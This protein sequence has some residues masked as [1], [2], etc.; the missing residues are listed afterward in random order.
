MVLSLDLDSTLV[1]DSFSPG[2]GLDTDDH[3]F[4]PANYTVIIELLIKSSMLLIEN[5]SLYPQT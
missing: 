5:L 3:N 4:G 2:L 1:L